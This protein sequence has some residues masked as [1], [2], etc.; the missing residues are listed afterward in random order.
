MK[1]HRMHFPPLICVLLLAAQV[2]GATTSHLDDAVARDFPDDGFSVWAGAEG[3]LNA[4][5]FKDAALILQRENANGSRR[6]I[7][8]VYFGNANGTYALA[9]RSHG[10]EFCNVRN[11]YNVDIIKGSVLIE[12]VHSVG[13]PVTST[14]IQ[15]RYEQDKG[16]FRLIGEQYLESYNQITDET[17]NSVNYITGR[18]IYTRRNQLGRKEVERRMEYPIIYLRDFECL[19]WGGFSQKVYIDESLSEKEY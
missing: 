16:D 19:S 7:F 15:F 14:V 6:E 3:D 9:S 17:R 11:F 1:I 18:A 5:G 13:E 2:S 4:D 8:V 10:D 12:L